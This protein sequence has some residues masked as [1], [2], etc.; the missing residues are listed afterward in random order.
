MAVLHSELSAGER[1]DEWWRIR[2]GETRFV[3]GARSAVFAPVRD[4]GLLVVDEEHEGAYKQEEG[5][6]YNGRDVAVVRAR[7][8]GAVAVLGSA[9]PSVESRTNVLSGK[10]ISLTLASRIGSQGLPTVSVVDRRKV[11]R[12]GGTPS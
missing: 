1:H 11:L 2:D 10:Y 3:I 6:R 12:E 7:L 5:P 8:E 9:T 4:L